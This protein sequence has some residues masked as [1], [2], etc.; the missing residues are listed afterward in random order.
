MSYL[1]RRGKKSSFGCEE[2]GCRE[3]VNDYNG[4]KY[5]QECGLVI[6]PEMV[7]GVE[8]DSEGDFVPRTADKGIL[9][10]KVDK[11]SHLL[12]KKYQK[13][14]NQRINLKFG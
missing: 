3:I 12:Q 6:M 4:Q 8:T 5:C 2:C 11:N 7:P 13:F 9:G 14:G 10:S 1:Q